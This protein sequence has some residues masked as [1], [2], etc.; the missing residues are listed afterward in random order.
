MVSLLAEQTQGVLRQQVGLRKHRRTG[1]H[2]DVV[3]R[4]AGALRG[5]VHV[6][7]AAHRSGEVFIQNTHLLV[8]ELQAL[9]VRWL[10]R[11]GDI[12]WHLMGK[13]N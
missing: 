7:D 11:I 3:L 8:G 2:E 5:Y 10:F 6:L 4:E 13:S 12:I 9:N 1:L